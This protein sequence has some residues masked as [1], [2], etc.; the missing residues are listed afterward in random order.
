M[1]PWYIDR[2]VG[3]HQFKNDPSL[4]QADIKLIADWADGGAPAGDPADMPPPR[5]FDDGTR[6]HIGEPDIVIKLRKEVIVKAKAPD[7]WVDLAMEDLGLKTDRYIRA[8][9]VKPSKG[10]AVV[11]HAVSYVHTPD[12]AGGEERGLLEEYAVGK[13]GDIFP[14]GTGRLLKVGTRVVMNAHLHSNGTDTPAD[15][16]VGIRLYPENYV[17]KRLL[18]MAHVGDNEDI[19]IPPNTK[20][21]RSEGYTMLL[22]P[23]RITAFQPHLHNRGQAQCLEL[24]YPPA[25]SGGRAAAQTVSC[26]DKFRFNWHI[27]YHYQED[28]Q[29]IVPAG[30]VIHVTSWYDNT[31]GNRF[32]PDPSNPVSFGQRSIDEMS[33]AWLSYYYLSDA[34]YRE[35]LSERQNKTNVVAGNR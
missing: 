33:F 35:M 2:T 20:N 6:W 5:Q 23:A 32:N 31:P 11:H 27:V 22:K 13:F 17:P 26:V 8:V 10:A 16:Y 29:P 15:I 3:I 18:I 24:I 25:Q 19:D 34:E 1:P 7:Q 14:E 21:V 12:G 28:V 4:S 9:E 30:T